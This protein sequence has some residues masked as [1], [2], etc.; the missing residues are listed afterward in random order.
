MAIIAK[1]KGGESNFEPTPEG[2]HI[3]RCVTVVD[4]GIQETKFGNKEQVYL[5]FE[6]PGHR[7]E[8]EDKDGNKHEGPGLIGRTYTSSINERSWLGQH[9]ESWRG[10]AFTETERQGFDLTNV[11]GA[12]CMIS[13]KHNTKGPKTY[14]NI[15]SI[16]KVPAGV[17]VPEAENELIAYSAGDNTL[18]K[19]P[20]W[21][22]EKV[23]AGW[24][25]AADAVNEPQA[26]DGIPP[27]E[28][29]TDTEFDDS[30]P[31]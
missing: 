29:Y 30:I 2:S 16:M 19:L 17:N 18:D 11:L 4:L 7:V 28:S 20:N 5:G 13:V 6:V 12:P 14:A 10:K 21:L 9:L 15:A 8:W 31:F 25:A 27:A 22:Q 26:T 24:G 23:R 3:A 1:D